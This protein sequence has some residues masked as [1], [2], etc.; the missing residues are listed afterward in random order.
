MIY[1]QCITDLTSIYI[2]AGYPSYT[3]G[4]YHGG[5]DTVHGNFLVYAPI[6]GTVVTAHKWSGGTTGADSWGN[7]IVVQMSDGNYWLAAHLAEQ[8]HSVNDV[9]TQGDYVGVQGV[10][11]NVTGKHTHW[12]YWVGGYGTD[13]RKDPS[14]VIRVPNS[15][16][17]Y[18]VE[19]DAGGIEPPGPDPEPIPGR[20]NKMPLWMYKGIL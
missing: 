4:G 2:S 12:E 6:S 18:T 7:Y 19:W 14:P 20:K 16:G 15:K 3:S 8:L 10:T 17:T 11:G 9:L 13:Y 5:I 1:K